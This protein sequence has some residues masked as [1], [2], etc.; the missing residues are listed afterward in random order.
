MAAAVHAAAPDLAVYARFHI[1]Q[2]VSPLGT[3]RIYL[4]NRGATTRR[5]KSGD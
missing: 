3:P 4:L 1:R 2:P 5:K